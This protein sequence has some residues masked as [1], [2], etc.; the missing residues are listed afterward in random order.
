MKRQNI[1]IIHV[2]QQTN[3]NRLPTYLRKAPNLLFQAL[4]LKLTKKINT[5]SQQR[6]LHHRLQLIDQQYRLDLHQNLWQSY[7]SLG[8]EHEIWANQVY[9]LANSNDHEQCQ[10]F[11]TNRLIELNR[12]IDQC[13]AELITQSRPCPKK[14][15]PIEELDCKL[16]EFVS[17][18]QTHLVKKINARLIRYQ[19]MIEEKK[20]FQILSTYTL[21]NIQKD[22]IDRLINLRQK[23]LEVFE[24]LLQFETQV[25]MELLSEDFDH[26]EMFIAPTLYSCIV[27][28]HLLTMTLKQKRYKTIQEIKRI[29]LNIYI[30]AYEI[31]YQDYEHQYKREL[32]NFKLISA[33][34]NQINEAT[35]PIDSF[36]TGSPKGL[37]LSETLCHIYAFHWQKLLLEKLSLQTQFFGRCQNQIFFTWNRSTNA[38]LEILQTFGSEHAHIEFDIK[39][40]S[41]VQFL[42]VHVSNYHGT[43]FTRVYHD[44]NS[45]KYTL[46]YV[47]GNSRSAHSHWLRSALIR[48]VRYCIS[49]YDFNQERLYLQA[50]CL[51]NGYSLEFV[52]DRVRHFFKHFDGISL[53]SVLNQDEYDKLRRRLMNYIDEQKEYNLKN[54]ELEKNKQLIRLN[55]LHEFGRK[56]EFNRQ[57]K[58]ILSTNLVDKKIPFIKQQLTINLKT[59]HQYSLNGLL[60]QQKPSH[61]LF[62][63]EKMFF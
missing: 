38:L 44:S 23:Q 52:D 32:D 48:A 12:Q 63:K 4:R 27:K 17:E 58:E 39:I 7:L 14:L 2:S 46:P 35:L 18:Q 6:F 54:K 36:M 43:L 9:K 49:V 30:D 37:V 31:Q 1:L 28:D 5:T 45:Q 53:L 22:I 56:H 62:N 59:I 20:L 21:T 3:D 50:T 55:Y 29:W 25:S 16:K 47:I 42:D 15:L 40:D 24:E 60:S 8:S 10:H 57:L 13:T 33:N 26:L 34:D 61:P 41:T 11:V 19:D 51:V